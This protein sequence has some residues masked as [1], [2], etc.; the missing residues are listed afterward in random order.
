[1]SSDSTK[2]PDNTAAGSDSTGVVRKPVTIPAKPDKKGDNS[3][4]STDNTRESDD[5][6][7][8]NDRELDVEMV[9]SEV[10]NAEAKSA[11][12]RKP[13]EI[14]SKPEGESDRV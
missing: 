3:D 4:P 7:T 1:V 6:S 10:T 13:I 8:K 9:A 14:E 11:V 12:T 5:F 2:I